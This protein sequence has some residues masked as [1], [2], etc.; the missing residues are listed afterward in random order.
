MRADGK[1]SAGWTQGWRE[2]RSRCNRPRSR[3]LIF[4]REPREIPEKLNDKTHLFYLAYFVC[5][6]VNQFRSGG[7]AGRSFNAGTGLVY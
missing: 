1:P 7:G 5:L 2:I 3:L 4:S 6:A